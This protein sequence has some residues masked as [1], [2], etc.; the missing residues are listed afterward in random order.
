[1]LKIIKKFKQKNILKIKNSTNQGFVIIFAVTISAIILAV[2][3]GVT[4]VAYQEIKFGTEARET[5]NAFLAADTGVECALY[6]DKQPNSLF[7]VAGPAAYLPCASVTPTYVSTN[8][9]GTYT[10]NVTGL[11][12]SSN[13]CA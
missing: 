4:K 8:K 9:T 10:F 3:L 7:S 5:N 1:M 11:G 12:S 2:A 6:S 13:S